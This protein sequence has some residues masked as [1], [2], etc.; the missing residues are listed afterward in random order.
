M[1][2]ADTPPQAYQQEIFQQ[3]RKEDQ[4]V[5]LARGLGLLRIVTNLLHSY[6]AAG[7]SLV[8]VVGATEAETDWIG[9]GSTA[10]SSEADCLLTLGSSRGSCGHVEKSAGSRL[11]NRKYRY[12][13]CR[14]EEEGVL[15]RRNPG[16]YIQNSYRGSLDEHPEAR[17]DNRNG[18]SSCREGYCNFD[19]SVHPSGV[20]TTQQIRLSESFLRQSGTI[21]DWNFPSVHHDAESS[22]SDSIVMA[23]VPRH[24]R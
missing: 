24:G 11:A 8:I 16:D 4:L 9:N 20:P 14:G 23:E 7:G 1:H 22:S 19:G 10:F 13:E 5:I 6:D 2:C 17:D 15:E 18:R 3:V 12:H 21:Y